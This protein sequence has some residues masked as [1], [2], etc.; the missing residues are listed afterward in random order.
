MVFSEISSNRQHRASREIDFE[1]KYC[2]E[3][4]H[5][6]SH[7]SDNRAFD[8]GVSRLDSN[9]R[10]DVSAHNSVRAPLDAIA[11]RN[12]CVRGPHRTDATRPKKMSPDG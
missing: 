8:P 9:P 5:T 3:R 12:V 1:C 11:R 4:M 2:C 10:S 6:Y 7:A